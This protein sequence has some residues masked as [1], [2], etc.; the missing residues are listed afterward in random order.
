MVR[1]TA[2][3]KHA[4]HTA[5]RVQD[6]EADSSAAEAKSAC[7]NVVHMDSCSQEETRRSISCNHI[8]DLSIQITSV[9]CRP[10]QCSEYVHKVLAAMTQCC[11]II[12]GKKGNA[13]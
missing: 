4:G 8:S 5:P 2:H 13:A 6:L 3:F 9:Q 10:V 11:N 12:E 7:C 1:S